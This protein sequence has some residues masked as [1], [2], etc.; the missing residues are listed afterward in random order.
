MLLRPG[1][2]LSEKLK[3]HNIKTHYVILVYGRKRKRILAIFDPEP[4]VYYYVNS[5]GS[6]SRIEVNENKI[7][8]VEVATDEQVKVFLADM[9]SFL[10]VK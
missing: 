6:S 8:G 2:K 3:K 7:K 5:D 1:T 9:D 4:H 10:D